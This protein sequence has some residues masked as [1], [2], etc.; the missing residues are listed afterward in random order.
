MQQMSDTYRKMLE[1]NLMH[2]IDKELEDPDYWGPKILDLSNRL[3]V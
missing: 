3:G 2:M 1:K